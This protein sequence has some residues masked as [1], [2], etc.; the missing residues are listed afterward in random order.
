MA[1]VSP[2]VVFRGLSVLLTVTTTLYYFKTPED[3]KRKASL[4]G[5]LGQPNAEFDWCERNFLSHPLVAEP[6]NSVSSLLYV[7]QPLIFLRLHQGIAMPAEL[8]FC[9]WTVGAIGLGSTAFHATLRYGLQLADE[10]PMFALVLGA[11]CALLRPTWGAGLPRAIATTLFGGLSVAL[12]STERDGE[13]AALHSACRGVL[14]CTFSACFVYIFWRTAA[15][16]RGDEVALSSHAASSLRAGPS[17]PDIFAKTF[18]IWMGTILCWIADILCCDT[19]QSLP[20]GLPFPHL[21]GFWHLGS[22]VGLHGIFVL[23]LL[24]ERLQHQS[25]E[26]VRT[27]VLWGF[28]PF[29]TE[30]SH[31][32]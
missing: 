15:L 13:S 3:L 25:S 30:G 22:A 9:L 32:A 16:A 14:S 26:N 17:P 12:L 23:L 10:L 28:V 1:G 8:T 19:L 24:H 27:S 29:L 4:A 5:P 20:F 31:N 2:T 21:H 18:S 7:A 6:V 11:S